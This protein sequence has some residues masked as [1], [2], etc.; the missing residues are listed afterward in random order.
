MRKIAVVTVGRSDYGIYLSLLRKLQVEPSVSLQLIVSGMHLSPEFGRT[1]T[2]IEADGFSVA[3]RVEM[4]VSSDTPEAIAKSMGLGTIGFAQAYARLEPNLVVVLG[5]RFEMHAAAVATVPF[6]LPLAHIHGGELTSGAIDDAFRHSITK[7]SHL[8]FVATDEYRRRVV[9]MGEDP[10]R[11]IVC[12]APNLDRL[13]EH[14]WLSTAELSE[15]YAIRLD[16]PPLLVTYHPVTREFERAEWQ[17]NELL[18]ALD[19]TGMPVIFTLPNADTSGRAVARAIRNFVANHEQAQM[20]E[21]FGDGYFSMMR[22]AAAM[23]GNSS[24]GVIEAASFELPVIN[25]GTRQNGRTRARNVIDCGYR[26]D[27]IGEAIR[28]G[29]SDDFRN[30]LRGITNPNGD[31]HAAERILQVLRTV[32]LDQS[33]LTKPFHDL[34]SPIPLRM[35]SEL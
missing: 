7:L 5:D 2:F 1:V 11:V 24:S 10:T 23:V 33:L 34:P 26:R 30:T 20:V 8:H 6:T 16:R 35:E 3:E 25:I 4:L 9:Q 12:G 29:L 27:E 19:T 21:N 31:G 14:K 32:E 13:R 15:H 17:I 22:H 28:R 18:A